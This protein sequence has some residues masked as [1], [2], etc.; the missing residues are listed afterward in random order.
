MGALAL[1]K[2]T[3][4]FLKGALRARLHLTLRTA[5]RYSVRIQK[6]ARESNNVA[7]QCIISTPQGLNNVA[8][9]CSEEQL[10]ARSRRHIAM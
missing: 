2:N 5:T 4:N 6:S 8:V 9:S 10:A 3:R 7:P 1:G